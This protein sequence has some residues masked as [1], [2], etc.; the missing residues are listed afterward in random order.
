MKALFITWDGPAQNYLE[1]LFF[2]I[3]ERVQAADLTIDTLQY[4]WGDETQRRSIEAAARRV[5][6]GYT[7]R[8]VL[9][10]PLAPATAAMIAKGAFDI[11]RQVREQDID[12]LFPRSLIPAAMSLLALE[13][14]DGVELVFDADGF[15]ADE[16]VEYG[17]WSAEGMI[18][19]VFRDIEAQ[20]VR[21]ARSIIT[22]TEHAKRILLE[23]AGAG[24]DASKIHVIPNARDEDEFR[25]V[26]GTRRAEIRTELGV[27]VQGPW[28]IYCGSLG[29]QYHPRELLEFFEQVRNRQDD[30]RLTILTGNQDIITQLL[31][32]FDIPEAVLDVRRVPPAEVPLFVAAA[33]L[34]I[35][36]RTPSFSQLGVCPIKVGEY[37]LCGTPVLSTTGVGDL[38]TQL[39][40]PDTGRLLDDLSGERLA[41]AADWFVDEV[42]PR[43]E[44][45]RLASREQG[46]EVFGLEMCA[47]RYR[48]AFET[49]RGA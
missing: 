41:E 25:P 45:H 11:V 14:L 23:R 43:R 33:D 42:L 37:L 19:R 6:L 28:V 2:P 8:K 32:E 36:F 21:R 1:S 34:G 9:R 44:D 48:K 30:A 22:R 46:V 4:T 5:G 27:P 18:Y 24:T 17:G 35:A 20:A 49:C 31:P 47:Q 26:E 13:R 39:D 40:K 12:V 29:P 7:A 16:R 3:Y 38:D 10:K 15:M